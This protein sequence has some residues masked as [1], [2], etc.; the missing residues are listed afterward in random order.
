MAKCKLLFRT[1]SGGQFFEPG[2]VVDLSN[3]DAET[4]L[5]LQGAER[6][7]DEARPE[8]HPAPEPSPNAPATDAAPAPGPAPTT[9]PKG[10]RKQK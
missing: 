10:D 8:A 3:E 5:A 7:A 6:V 4:L 2:S 9:P 1:H